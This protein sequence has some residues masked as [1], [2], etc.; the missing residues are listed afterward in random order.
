V[1][2]AGEAYFDVQHD[3]KKPFSIQTRNTIIRVLGTRFL[4]R[5]SIQAEQIFVSRGSV[6]I[7]ERTDSSKHIIISTGQSVSIIGKIFDKESITDSNYLSWQ[8]G[9]LQF[10]NVTLR[11]MI[12]DLNQNFQV[13]ISLADPLAAK[14]DTIRVNFRFENNSLDQVL[15]EIHVTTGWVVERKG[16]EIILRE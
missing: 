11:K 12:L 9:I 6:R 2:L 3:E 8:S 5:S 14:S 4:V 7:T 1:E 15:D 13:N 10:D 16:N